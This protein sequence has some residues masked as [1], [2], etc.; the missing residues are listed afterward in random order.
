MQTRVIIAAQIKELLNQYLFF[1][2]E[3]P[4]LISAQEVDISHEIFSLWYG[5]LRDLMGTLY[6]D[7]RI[8]RGKPWSSYT[9]LTAHQ[10]MVLV[11]PSCMLKR[12]VCVFGRHSAIC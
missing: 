12:D 7:I 8:I 3:V 11:Q 10:H 2:S 5:G 1:S 4:Y 9:F 6:M